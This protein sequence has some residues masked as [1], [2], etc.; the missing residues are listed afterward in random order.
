MLFTIYKTTNLI[1]GKIYIG[2]HRTEIQNDSYLG[3]GNQL[4]AA[5]KK[6]G[7]CNFIKEILFVF[8]NS[9]DM[10]IKERELV[11]EEFVKRPDTYNICVGGVGGF[12]DPV[13]AKRGRYLTD[14]HL[15][16]KYGQDFRSVLGKLGAEGSK[17]YYE[18]G[19][20]DPEFAGNKRKLA[21]HASAF[22]QSE[23][24]KAKRVDTFTKIGHQQGVKNSAYGKMWITDGHDS[25]MIVREHPIPNGWYK[26]RVTK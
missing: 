16:S 14:K 20:K 25:K 17:R 23:E 8:D 6:Y 10:F 2:C 9:E 24:A 7:R 22:A 12:S 1:N 3:S 21:N 11:N 18:T 15:E 13:L 5:I 26:G 4:I 19:M